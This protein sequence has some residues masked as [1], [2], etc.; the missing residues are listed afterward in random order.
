MLGAHLLYHLAP[1]QTRLIATYRASS[2]LDLAEKIF[3]YYESGQELWKRVEWIETDLE[4]PVQVNNLLTDVDELYHCAALVSF[5]PL[6]GP[7]MLEINSL[8][9]ENLV[10]AG[11]ENG[12]AKMVHVSSVAALGRDAQRTKISE[13]SHW[14]ADGENSV[15]AKSKY[16]SELEVWRGAAEGLKVA[17][18]NPGVILGPGDWTTGSARLFYSMAQNFR[19]YTEGVNGFVDVRDVA[20]VMIKLMDSEISDERFVVVAENRS[21]KDLFFNIADALGSKRP[22]VKAQPWMGELVWR[23]ERLKSLITSKKPLVTPETART[24]HQANHYDN[25]K[26]REALNFE[27]RPLEETVQDFARLYQADAKN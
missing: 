5:D 26:I 20:E 27:F 22:S 7:A 3:S 4:D 15:Y 13:K 1:Q 6:D 8:I 12:L 19:Y 25:S 17:V 11:L 21:Y 9:T 14:N 18:V 24:A 23:A 2:N 10:N 16:K